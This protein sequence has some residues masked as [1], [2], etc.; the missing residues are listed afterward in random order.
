MNDV[1]VDGGADGADGADGSAPGSANNVMNGERRKAAL[2][3]D[4]EKLRNELCRQMEEDLRL[5]REYQQVFQ[6]I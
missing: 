4:G 5:Q 6:F 2:V 1:V 3:M